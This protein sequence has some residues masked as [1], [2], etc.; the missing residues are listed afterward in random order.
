M[1]DFFDK[2]DKCRKPGFLGQY[3][4]FLHFYG[5]FRSFFK[6]NQHFSLS[7]FLSL[8]LFCSSISSLGL[9]FLQSRIP[10]LPN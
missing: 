1:F 6:Q 10:G 7:L 3:I 8:S 5:S 9:H 2:R 4:H